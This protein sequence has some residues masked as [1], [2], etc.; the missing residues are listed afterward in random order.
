[1]SWWGWAAMRGARL[2]HP[3]GVVFDATFTVAG[4][5]H[6]G[7]PLL[8]QPGEH[9]TLVRLSK[10]TFT[11]GRLPDMLGLAFR[12]TDADGEGVPLALALATTGIRPVCGTSWHPATTSP[13]PTRRSCPTRWAPVIAWWP[14]HPPTPPAPSAPTWPHSPDSSPPRR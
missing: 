3:R 2:F 1:M 10:A 8:D 7:V 9:R 4:T 12:I 6:H 14:R 11:P 13:P 5:D